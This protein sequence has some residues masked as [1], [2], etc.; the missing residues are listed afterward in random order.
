MKRRTRI[1]LG[2]AVI[3][4]VVAPVGTFTGG[5]AMAAP[6][7]QAPANYTCSGGNIQ[8]GTFSLIPS[9]TYANLTI[10]GACQPGFDA[11]INVL[12]SVHVGEHAVFDAQSRPATITVG[13]NVTAGSGSLLGLGCLPNPSPT[14][15]TGHPC[16]DAK[17]NPTLGHSKITIDGDVLA[18]NADTVLLNGITVEGSVALI[19]GG[20]AIP[21]AIKT[22]TIDGNFLVSNVTPD[23][24]G[25]IVNNVGGS[26]ILLDIRI[27]DTDP[28]PAIFVASNTVGQN[29]ACYGLAPA[30]SGGF[31]N[32]HNVVGGHTFGQCEHLMDE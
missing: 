15:S 10:T 27:T 24:F 30:V 28:N 9:G 16:V 17:G 6:S 7:V 13:H 20:G 19:G 8:T 32:E 5:S 23:W 18:W 4:G 3:I 2:V 31:G 14:N 22:N 12:G 26:M 29:L 25:A 11:V 1:L 21:W